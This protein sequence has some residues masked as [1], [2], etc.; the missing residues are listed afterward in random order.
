LKRD[1]NERTEERIRRD[2]ASTGRF[3][4]NR[5]SSAPV[6]MGCP[7]SMHGENIMTL[8]VTC[9]GLSNTGRLTA[10]A[11]QFLLQ[12]DP[13][14]IVWVPAQKSPEDLNDI[15]GD[16]RKVI[17]LNGCTDRCATKK[18]RA[19]GFAEGTELIV[20]DLGIEKKGMDEVRFAEIGI[21]AMAVMDIIRNGST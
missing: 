2:F 13:G 5:I 14:S 21:V 9:S 1:G 16:A 20:T 6:P 3:G 12:K 8:L 19:A 11:A 4:D 17:I 15:A 10:Q 7:L 18:L